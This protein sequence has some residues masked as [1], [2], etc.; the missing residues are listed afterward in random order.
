MRLLHLPL[1]VDD[2]SVSGDNEEIQVVKY[3]F[4][5]FS[6]LYQTEQQSQL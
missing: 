6:G 3:I 5:I 4:Y 2:Q 1:P